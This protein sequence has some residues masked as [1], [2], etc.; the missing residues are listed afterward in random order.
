MEKQTVIKS[1]LTKM[2]IG[3]SIHFPLNKR[4]SIR[5]T[6]SNLKLDGYLFKTKMQ[7]KENLI[8]VTRKK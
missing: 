5:T 7:I 6:A 4:G 1:T 8:I 3:G 2:P